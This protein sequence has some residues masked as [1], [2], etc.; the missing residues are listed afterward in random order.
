MRRDLNDY[1]NRNRY[2]NRRRKKKGKDKKRL[3][4][5]RENAGIAK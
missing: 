3:R 5:D 4:T 1:A 2:K